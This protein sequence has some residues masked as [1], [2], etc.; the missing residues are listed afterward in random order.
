MTVFTCQELPPAHQVLVACF[1]TT[2]ERLRPALQRCV[3]AGADLPFVAAVHGLP[4]LLYRRLRE[5]GLDGMLPAGQWEALQRRYLRGVQ[6]QEAMLAMAAEAAGLLAGAQVP[7]VALKGLAAAATA[8]NAPLPREMVDLDLLVPPGEIVRA[9][10]VLL[11]H[12]YERARYPWAPTPWEYHLPRL[13]KRGLP[14]EM[15]WRLWPR[16]PLQPFDLPGAATLLAESVPGEAGGVP[17]LAPALPW[18]IIVTAAGMAVDGLAAYLRQWV[19]LKRLWEQLAPEQEQRLWD[20][21]ER[22]RMRGYLQVMLKLAAELW[23]DMRKSAVALDEA[24]EALERLRPVAWRR[25][26]AAPVRRASF[27]ML[28]TVRRLQGAGLLREAEWTEHL[29][30]EV[31]SRSVQRASRG[32]VAQTGGVLVATGRLLGRTGAWVVDRRERQALA[33]ELLVSRVL[34]E[35]A[36]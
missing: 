13:E 22:C 17:V 24:S 7:C 34:A 10:E 11:A 6:R 28:L 1:D 32:A 18:Q 27:W 12:G 4:P 9:T 25:L 35:L 2:D 31:R 33:E 26:A 15:H 8:M 3:A 20:V 23:P 21:A 29:P 14:L 36:Q 19:D 16:G 30:P 5:T